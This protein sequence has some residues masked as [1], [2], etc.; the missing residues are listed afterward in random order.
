[1]TRESSLYF[2]SAETPAFSDTKIHYSLFVT[3]SGKCNWNGASF[4][5]SSPYCFIVR[6]ILVW[7]ILIKVQCKPQVMIIISLQ[8]PTLNFTYKLW[9]HTKTPTTTTAIKTTDVL[10]KFWRHTEMCVTSAMYSGDPKFRSWPG[11]V[12]L[13]KILHDGLCSSAILRGVGRQMVVGSWWKTTNLRCVIYLKTRSQIHYGRSLKSRILQD[14]PQL[15]Q[16]PT[17]CLK[18]GHYC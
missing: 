17:R 9:H 11:K 15:L 8:A 12:T 3:Y 16:M 4:R 1:M 5:K 13:I 6:H 2:H 14:I 10:N 7:S 18:V